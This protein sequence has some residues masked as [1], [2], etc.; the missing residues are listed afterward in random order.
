MGNTAVFL[1]NE[2]CNEDHPHI[3]GEYLSLPSSIP[4]ISGSPPHTW[5]IR[6][7]GAYTLDLGRITPT[8]MGNTPTLLSNGTHPGDHPHIH[9]EYE[10]TCC[11]QT[12]ISGSPP[13]TWGIPVEPP[14]GVYVLRITPTYM[15]NTK[16]VQK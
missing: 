7:N 5:G 13:H 15:G 14:F 6:G 3:H 12:W 16:G 4:P 2:K 10:L 9:G 8:Y 1:C 11:L